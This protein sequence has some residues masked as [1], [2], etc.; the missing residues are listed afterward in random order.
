MIKKKKKFISISELNNR[1]NE[2]IRIGEVGTELIHK[3]NYVK[4]G[5]GFFLCGVG[6]ITLPLPTGSILLIG[7][8]LGFI[9]SGGVDI[10]AYKK[11][12]FREIKLYKMRFFL[13]NGK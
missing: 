3:V 7:I 2:L 4:V 13:T 9:T 12:L 6:L 5:L 11:R 10:L 8:G 1:Y